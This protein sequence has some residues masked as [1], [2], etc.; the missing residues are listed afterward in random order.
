[1][2]NFS[3]Q[4]HM[5]PGMRQVIYNVFLNI[6]EVAMNTYHYSRYTITR[7]INLSVLFSGKKP[8]GLQCPKY[9]NIDLLYSFRFR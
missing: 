3:A 8:G 9:N 6:G 5:R 1:M 2:A 4:K 7:M